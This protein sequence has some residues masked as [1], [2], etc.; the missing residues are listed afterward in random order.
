MKQNGEDIAIYQHHDKNEMKASIIAQLAD[1]GK[2]FRLRTIKKP[3]LD[4]GVIVYRSA[5]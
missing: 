2:S 1:N 4:Y 5:F 3:M